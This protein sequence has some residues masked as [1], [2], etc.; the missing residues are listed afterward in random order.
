MCIAWPLLLL[1][2]V[3]TCSRRPGKVAPYQ[4]SNDTLN[5]SDIPKWSVKRGIELV[6]LNV[7]LL[8]QTMI[9]KI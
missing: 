6:S 8:L 2:S 9:K 1:A 5:S 4:L 3:S 7:M